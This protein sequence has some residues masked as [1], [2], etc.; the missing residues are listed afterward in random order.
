MAHPRELLDHEL[1]GWYLT[2]FDGRVLDCNNSMARMLGFRSRQGL[3]RAPAQSLYIS[4]EDRRAFLKRLRA[5]G[6][7][8][9]NE[10]TLLARNGEQV[11]ILENVRL[12]R[13]KGNRRALIQGVMVNIT[14]R[15]RSEIALRESVRT[16][17][18]LADELRMLSRH[19]EAIRERERV[20]I[21]RDLHDELGQ[22]LTALSMDLHWLRDGGDSTDRSAL[23]RSMCDEASRAIRSVRRICADLRPTILDDLGLAA[24]IVWQARE[25]ESRTAIPCECRAPRSLCRVDRLQAYALYRIVQESLT[26]VARHASATRV[27]VGLQVRRDRIEL[28]VTD[29]GRGIEVGDAF[30]PSS[31]GILGMRER[32]LH[33]RGELT[34]QRTGRRGTKVHLA[35]PLGRPGDGAA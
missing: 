21:A 18:D 23:I 32:A 9:G 26:N 25:F 20:R 14:D 24:A 27:R 33:W 6:E 17:H 16:A 7:L 10:L 3:L 13:K 12:V 2:T 5:R 4:D 31:F 15:K 8:I 28:E 19:G 22:T 29:D 35:M 11:H 1:I 30:K 34:V